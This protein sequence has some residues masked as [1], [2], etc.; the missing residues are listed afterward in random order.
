MESGFEIS[1]LINEKLC[2]AL[3]LSEYSIQTDSRKVD[4]DSVFVAYKGLKTDSHLHIEEVIKKGVRVIICEEIIVNVTNVV[5]IKVKNSR[6]AWS[7]ICR[8]A[9]NN[10]DESLEI[11]GI[12]GTNGKTSTAWYVWQ[13]LNFAKIPCGMI[14]TLGI[15]YQNNLE[16][17]KLTTPDPDQF[18]SVLSQMRSQGIQVVVME[19]SSQSLLHNRIAGIKMKAIGF[20]SF[21]QD[22]LDLHGS[23]DEYLDAKL[24]IFTDYSTPI[25]TIAIHQNVAMKIIRRRPKFFETL[26]FSEGFEYI[27]GEKTSSETTIKKLEPVSIAET[28]REILFSRK[29]MVSKLKIDLI[30]DFLLENFCC[31]LLLAESVGFQIKDQ[32]SFTQIQP[33]PGRM[34]KISKTNGTKIFIDYAHT[35]DALERALLSIGKAKDSCLWLVFGCGGDRDRAKR[36]LMGKIAA[37]AADRVIL[38]SDNPRSEDPHLIINEIASGFSAGYNSYE[39]IEDRYEAIYFALKMAGAKDSVLIAGKGHETTQTIGKKINVFDDR[40]TV[41]D[42]LEKL[43]S[44]VEPH[45]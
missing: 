35:P 19:V 32:M 30:S 42:I 17:G 34:E 36:S 8:Q 9:F 6:K 14:G 2:S 20:T 12:T 26:K 5:F 43:G 38:T 21:T 13:L 3:S 11:I 4:A 31:A 40:Q 25:T 27:F 1:E 22:H 33:V 44:Q 10:P 16:A 28:K 37:R 39:V 15:A 18:F 7:L 24:K 45:N 23:M 29:A 41:K